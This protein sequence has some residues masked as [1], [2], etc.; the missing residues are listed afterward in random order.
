[1]I[2]AV[3]VLNRM[4]EFR[5]TSWLHH[6]VRQIAGDESLAVTIKGDCM[7]PWIESDSLVHVAP[8]RIYWPGDIVVVLSRQG[9]YLSHRVIGLYRRQGMLKVITQADSSHR[10]DAAVRVNAILG[11]VSGGF[12]H[13]HA[14]DIPLSH[15][16]KALLR[17]VRLLIRKCR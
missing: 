14:V 15:R 16:I 10:P 1:M 7:T 3:R 6:R 11:K 5:S 12:C 2:P 9:R 17:F 4:G 13:P 8:C